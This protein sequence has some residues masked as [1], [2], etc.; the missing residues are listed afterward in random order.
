[1]S[2]NNN[3]GLKK[4]KIGK[5]S[6]KK[7]DLP[8]GLWIK[9]THCSTVDPIYVKE[10][11]KNLNIC[12]RC[13]WHYTMTSQERIASLID[14]NSFEE[15]GGGLS[16]DDP[17]EF[18]TSES[19]KDKI[20][21]LQDQTGLR[22][23][24]ITGKC[25]IGGRP[26]VLGIMDSRFIMASMGS[27]VGEKVTLAAEMA[28]AE[29]IPLII[30]AASGGARMQ[31]G[32]I[33]LMQMAKTSAAIDRLDRSGGLFISVLTNPTMA[34]VM[35]SFAALGDVIIAEPHALIGFTGPRVIEKTLQTTLP[36]G[37][38][39]AEFL[40]EHGQLDIIVNRKEMK[41]TIATLMDYFSANKK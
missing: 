39:E 20:L 34:G 3:D 27:V 24:M 1:M 2:Y 21:T 18:R 6:K 40:L 14:E 26:C 32:A 29:K 5:D 10:L 22:E 13:G 37:F 15:F 23:A 41:N 28:T 35:A 17:L 30:F 19:Y 7:K 9:C 8:D 16:P 38:Q 33:S 36:E 12:P 11:E 31:E 25:K 4:I